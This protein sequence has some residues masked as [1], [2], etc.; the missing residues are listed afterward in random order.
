MFLSEKDPP[1]GNLKLFFSQFFL[2]QKSLLEPNNS[3]QNGYSMAKNLHEGALLSTQS[4]GEYNLQITN[5]EISMID[6]LAKGKFHQRHF[7]EICRH[8]S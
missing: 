2:D 5:G 4:S 3:I 8:V 6:S 7:E 1:S